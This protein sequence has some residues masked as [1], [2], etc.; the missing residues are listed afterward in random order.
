MASLAIQFRVRALQT[1][2]RL[3]VV[4]GQTFDEIFGGMTLLT[5]FG[6]QL[7]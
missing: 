6:R 3:I 4:E 5:A 7:L 2:P 1:I